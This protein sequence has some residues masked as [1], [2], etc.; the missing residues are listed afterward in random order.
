[1]RTTAGFAYMASRWPSDIAVSGGLAGDGGVGVEELEAAVI[2][3]GLSPCADFPQTASEQVI[4]LGNTSKPSRLNSHFP[5]F[6]PSETENVCSRGGP[7]CPTV[8]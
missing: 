2:S 3:S 5:F 6:L 1:M 7:N 8:T 4:G